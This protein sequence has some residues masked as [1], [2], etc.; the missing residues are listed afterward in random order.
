VLVHHAVQVLV[1][2]LLSQLELVVQ[3]LLLQLMQLVVS[4]VA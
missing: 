4:V 1:E 3:T 2:L